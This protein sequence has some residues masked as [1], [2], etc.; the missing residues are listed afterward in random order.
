VPVTFSPK[1]K[2]IADLVG[3]NGIFLRLWRGIFRLGFKNMKNPAKVEKK[4][5]ENIDSGTPLI[6]IGAIILPQLRLWR[7][8]NRKGITK[9]V[10]DALII[11]NIPTLRIETWQRKLLNVQNH[12]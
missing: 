8:E 5:I 9:Q 1:S 12:T 6:N 3:F 11:L 10:V 4:C 7:N 2:I